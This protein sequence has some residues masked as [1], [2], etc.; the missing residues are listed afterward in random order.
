MLLALTTT[1]RALG[2]ARH[3]LDRLRLLPDRRDRVRLLHGALT[4][5]DAR[6]TGFDAAAVEVI[7]HRRNPRH[8]RP[9]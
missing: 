2:V 1:Y 9:V 7:E 3:R 5:R 8:P 6:L 4:Y